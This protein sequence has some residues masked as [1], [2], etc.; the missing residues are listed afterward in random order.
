[1]KFGKL[2]VDSYC[3]IFLPDIGTFFNKNLD[4]AFDLIVKLTKSKVKV[5]KGEILHNANICFRD[6]SSIEYYDKSKVKNEE[7]YRKLIERKV[8]SLETYKK[9]IDFCKNY[10]LETI[11]SVYDIDAAK[12]A[13]LNGV[14]ALKIAS[15]NIVHKPLISFCA[16]LDLPTIMDTGDSSIEEIARAVEWWQVESKNSNNLIVEHSPYP[17]PKSLKD[18]NLNLMVNLGKL[19]NLPFGLSD[20]HIGD[21]MLY[22]A[23]ALG[24][25]ILEKGV[26]PD[27]LYKEQDILHSLPVSKVKS[28]IEKCNNIRKA[29]GNGSRYLN[30]ERKRKISRMCLVAK[31]NLKKG[32]LINLKNIAFSFPVKGIQVEMWDLVSN[33]SLNKSI[34]KNHPIRINDVKI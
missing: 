3:P 21:E 22:A 10:G 9:I 1:M 26:S 5:I 7:N 29:M 19:F 4:I 2:K 13:K 25:I 33:K 8:N 16:K 23:T 32:D 17:Y 34:L 20:H 18:H 27:Q 15:S 11:F 14:S 30:P 12:F 24:A 28:V 6:F 31:K